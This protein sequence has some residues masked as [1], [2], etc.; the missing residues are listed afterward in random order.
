MK[1][2]IIIN[3]SS[4]VCSKKFEPISPKTDKTRGAGGIPPQTPLP[5][6]PRK[7]TF[8]D[9][10]ISSFSNPPK[11]DCSASPS[12]AANSFINLY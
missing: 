9:W 10:T 12:L 2:K 7:A 11:A 1:N 4:G 5:P 6:A 8:S 3:S